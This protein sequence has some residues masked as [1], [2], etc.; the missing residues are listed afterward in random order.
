[1]KIKGP[2]ELKW[3]YDSLCM[4]LLAPAGVWALWAPLQHFP[5]RSS[6]D[7]VLVSW[8]SSPQCPSG[9]P[10]LWASSHHGDS[11]SLGA[12]SPLM[13][14]RQELWICM[15]KWT[16]R[17]EPQ[18]FYCSRALPKLTELLALSGRH[19]AGPIDSNP[20]CVRDEG[21]DCSVT[22]KQLLL[23]KFPWWFCRL[24]G[25]L[26]FCFFWS[27]HLELFCCVKWR[28]H[29]KSSRIHTEQNKVS[30]QFF[31]VAFAFFIPDASYKTQVFT[32]WT[33]VY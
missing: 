2:F 10:E 33:T 9:V 31:D 25:F 7:G 3:F 19:S 20:D 11:W 23:Y 17:V 12:S 15:V 21:F 13:A 6:W 32:S 30:V 1:M 24:L 14:K 22:W 27:L 5:V 18:D 26:L 8:A 4:A 28:L 16:S 29:T